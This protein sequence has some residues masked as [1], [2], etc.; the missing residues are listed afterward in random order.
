MYNTYPRGADCYCSP[1][2]GCFHKHFQV[3]P[4]ITNTGDD[5]ILYG[6][7]IGTH[8]YDYYLEVTAV[9]NARMTTVKTHKVYS[10]CRI[11]KAS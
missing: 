1:Y 7:E 4:R 3:K 5:G 10:T 8:D 9:N 2:N 6:M 11:K